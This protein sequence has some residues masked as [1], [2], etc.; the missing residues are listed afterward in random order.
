MEDTPAGQSG[1]KGL[2]GAGSAL[3]MC[4]TPVH[5]QTETEFKWRRSA[6]AMTGQDEHTQQWRVSA[7]SFV[8]PEQWASGPAARPPRRWHSGRQIFLAVLLFLLTAG[9]T[10]ITWG[11]AYCIGILLI[12]LSHEMGHYLM[13][14][15][16]GLIATLPFF[17]PLPLISPFGTL[18]AI[19]L[20]RRASRDRRVQFDIGIAGPLAGIVPAIAVLAWGLARSEVVMEFPVDTP[21]LRLGSSLLYAGLRGLVLTGL[22]EGAKVMLHPAAYAGWAGLF[23]TALN[24]IPVGQLDGGH[25]VRGL[26]GRH[27]PKVFILVMIGLVGLALYNPLWWAFVLLLL[28][29]LLRRRLPEV[30][31][32]RPLGVGRVILGIL[33]LAIFVL[34]FTPRPFHIE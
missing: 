20:M 23:V 10:Y 22:P 13:C 21:T 27:A 14:R 8:P 19:I 16:Y 6:S 34:C 3:V 28:L 26:L 1:H 11:P 17:I 9:S 12:L 18:G 2:H 24:L 32:S 30:D 29:M 7:P 4:G 33:A 5:S 31:D 15:R 25:V